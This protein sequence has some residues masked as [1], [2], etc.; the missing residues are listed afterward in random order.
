MIELFKANLHKTKH[1]RSY[2][3][4][5]F[6]KFNQILSETLSIYC[7]SEYFGY[8]PS[9]VKDTTFNPHKNP[10]RLRLL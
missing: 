5:K 10:K 4:S 8:T 9:S 7:R 1:L 6:Q 2:S 3:W